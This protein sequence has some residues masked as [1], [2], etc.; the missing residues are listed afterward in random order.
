[1]EDRPVSPALKIAAFVMF[2]FLLAPVLLVVPISFS[3]DSY[4]S[5]PPSGWSL[6]W[7]IELM[8]NSR[9]IGAL[10]T[11]TLLAVIV[12]VLAMVIALP[13]AYAI[14][15]MRVIGGEALL[16]LF[17]APLLLP[18]I[19]LGL[20]ILIVFAGAG[21]LATFPGLVI[22]HLIIV[23]PYALRVL[24]TSLSGLPIIMEEAASTL[25]ASP[26]TVFR[27]I[28]LPMMMPGMVATAALSFLV[29]FDEAV[30]SLFLT[31]PRITTLPVALYQHVEN[32]A[33]PLVA[34]VSVL[35][36]VLTLAVVLIVD[37][38]AGL[39]KTFVK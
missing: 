7:Y 16:A 38:T 23:L 33:D 26:L 2:A 5:F 13:A 22:A 11:S 39:T 28:T 1:M 37:R 4:M 29:S 25:G 35:L 3:A 12:M 8:D 10:G 36:I 24:T 14:V 34:A 9:M 17:T 21:L 19:V 30:I 18:T 32:Q 27:R 31:G 15:R 6:R 20:A